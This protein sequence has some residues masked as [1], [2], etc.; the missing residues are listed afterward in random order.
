MELEILRDG[1]R[2][3]RTVEL[4]ERQGEQVAEAESKEKEGSRGFSWLG[5]EYQDLTP[6]MRQS[7]GISGS[8]E[9]VLV[10]EITATSPLYDEG[11]TEGDLIVEVN[12]EPVP[13]V[14]EFER[15][16]G[17]S[18][19]GSFLRFYLRRINPQAPQGPGNRQVNY[20][21]IVRVP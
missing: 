5:L 19:S 10:R 3:R 14:R 9:G 4:T 2:L 13:N 15:L 8:V 20:F 11:V 16:V 18:A 6:A 17:A 1:K 21:A 7:L 12:G